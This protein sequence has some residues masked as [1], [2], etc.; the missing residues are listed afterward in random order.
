MALVLRLCTLVVL[1]SCVVVASTATGGEIS[2]FGPK[3]YLRTTGAPNVYQD[4]FAAEPGEAR[5]TIRNGREGQ[6]SNADDRVTSGV[7][8]LNG[9]VLF[10]HDDFKHQTYILE[11]PVILS[12]DNEIRVELESKPGSYLALEIIRTVA[13]PLNDLLAANLAG[14][15]TNC[16]QT[17]DLTVDITNQGEAEIPAGVRVALYN[18][19][20]EDGGQLIG[21]SETTEKLLPTETETVVYRWS[22]P[23]TGD[24]AIFARVD[25]DG[26]GVGHIE[27]IDEL[28]NLVAAEL[29]LCREMP[30]GDSSIA[31]KVIDAVSGAGL[32]D[33]Q[34]VLRPE[35]NGT[36]G[37]AVATARSDA[38]GAFLFA[39]LA[40]GTYQIA[41]VHQ[42][43][44]DNSK[45]VV[46]GEGVDLADQDLVL[47]PVLAD[48]EIRI[49]LTWNQSPADLE[50]HLTQPND[51]GC[52]YHCYYFNK[53]IPTASLDLDDR[54][55][56][57]PE[58]ITITDKIPGTY[59][60]YV[61]DFTNRYANSRWLSLSGAQVKV[62]AGNH[63]PLIFTV[64]G[65]YGN[66]W[67]VFDLNGETGEIVP[68]HALSNQSEPGKIDYPVITSS[69]GGR[70]YW[71]SLYTY[72]VQAT[73]PDNDPLVYALDK[74]PAGMTIDAA[75]G[76]VQWRPS[77]AQSGRYD[78][79]VKVTDDRCGEA[80]QSFTIYVYSQ[81]TAQ[82]SVDPCSGSNPGGDITLK[83]S[84]TL[85]ATVLIEP[86]IGVVEKNGALTIP[87]PAEPTVYT[88]TAFNDAALTKRTVPGLPSASFYFSPNRVYKGQ[89]TTL[90]WTP[91]CANEAVI[92]HDIGTV[93]AAGS[94]NLTPTATTTYNM[95]VGNAAG[96]RNYAATVYVVEP[97]PPSPPSIN[98]S[99]SPTC[100]LTPGEP[101]TLT[102]STSNATSAVISPDIGEVPLAGSQQVTP[103]TAGSYTLEAT[104]D[105]GIRSRTVAYPNYPGVSFSASTYSIDP[106]DS[107]DL[108]WSAGCADTVVINQGIGTVAAQGNLT[109]T[110]PSLPLTYTIT[111]ANERGPVSRSV[112][113]AP[114]GPAG[115]LAADPAVL[116]VG[117]S[118][119]LTWSSTRATS[120]AITPDVGEVDCNGSITITPTRPT[121]YSLK[122]VGPG[123]TAYR[124]VAVSFV[125]PVADLKASA[126]TIK[127]G[128]SV[129]LTW[130]YANATSC[131][132]DQNIG[133]VELGGEITVTP[134]VTTTYT[135][136]STGPGGVARDSVTITVIPANPPPTMTLT[137]GENIILRGSATTLSWDS[138]YADAV[139]I[140]PGIG[141]VAVSGS[142]TVA[143]ETTTIYTAT[144]TGPGGAATAARTITVLQPAPILSLHAVPAAIAGGDSAQL[145]WASTN[146]DQVV[147]NQGIGAVGAEGS[148]AVSPGQ[149]TTYIA[150][151]TGPGGTVAKNVTVTVSQPQPTATLSAAPLAV[152]A[153][154]PTELSWTTAN[155]DTV[156]ISPD[157]G[158]VATT[159]A[160]AVTPTATTTYTL[161]ATG[162]G[163]TVEESV[164]ITVYPELVLQVDSPVAGAVTAT[165]TVAV[166]G[167][168]TTGAAVT[169]NG[170]PATVLGAGFSAEVVLATEG[171]HNL[172]VEAVD[173]YGRRQAVTVTI[174]YMA[175][176]T[177]AIA[178]DR[179]RIAAGDTVTLTWS[180]ENCLSAAITPDPGEVECTGTAQVS[181]AVTTEYIIS[182]RGDADK[183][184]R[185]GVIVVVADPYGDPSA[186]EQAHLE[187]INRARAN[188]AAEAARLG[189]D[190]NEG[191]PEAVIDAAPLPPLTFNATLARA[192]RGHSED[193]VI[194]HYF[195]HEGSD[196]SSPADRCLAAGYVGSTGEN[197]AAVTASDPMDPVRTALQLH[198]NLFVDADYSGRGHRLNILGAEWS[199]IGIG[200]L[201]D[202]VQADAPY[203]GV[204]TCNFGAN[205][206]GGH[207]LL[208]VVYAD[209][210]GDQVYDGGEGVGQ[211][212]VRDRTS[213]AMTY[214]AAA[215][216]YSLPLAD[217]DHTIEVSLADGRTLSRQI[218]M[219][220]ANLKHDFEVGMF[221]DHPPT[222]QFTS[223]DQAVRPGQTTWLEWT[224]TDA[225]YAAIDNGIGYL[226]VNGA[227]A[228]APAETTTYTLTVTGRGGTVTATATVYVSEFIVQ[229]TIAFSAA[230]LTVAKGEATTL[231]W[232]T[233]DAQGVH[234]DNGVGAVAL[235]GSVTVAPDH[236]TTYTLTAV[237]PG[238]VANARVRVLVTGE[239]PPQPAG[240]FG[241]LYNSSIPTD[242]TVEN[243]D[244]ARFALATGAVN[245]R[246]GTPV[247][248]VAVTV[249]HHP[250]YGT[251]VTD[252]GGRFVLPVEGGATYTL[253]YGGAG[254][255]PL[256]RQLYVPVNDI[257]IAPTVQLLKQ[258]GLTTTVRLDGD[259]ATITT[260]RSS[261]VTDDS[262]SRALT[263]VFQGDNRAFAV[264]ED[265]RVV[266]ELRN[267]TV[268]ATEYPTSASMPAELPKTSAYT[269]CAE[270]E[271]DG[272]DRVRFDRP[273]VTWVDNFLGFEVGAAVPVG[274]YDRD[275]GIWVPSRNGVV[276]TLVDS[277]GDGAVDGVDRD[278]DGQADDIDGDGDLRDEAF[279]LADPQFYRPGAEFWRVEV[280][281]FSP[282]DFNW[283]SLISLLN[284]LGFNPPSL[285]EQL[286]P[287]CPQSATGSSVGDASQIYYENIAI[288]GTGLSLAYASDRADGYRQVI[289]VP[290]SGAEVPASVKRIEVE[291]HIAGRK[292]TRTLEPSP[293]QVTEFVWDGRDLLNNR[294]LHKVT[295]EV[296][297][298]YVYDSYY[299]D[300]GYLA[301]AFGWFGTTPTAVPTRDEVINWRRSQLVINPAEKG[302]GLA[303]GWS[304]SAHHRLSPTDPT[305][306]HKGD[307]T[308]IRNATPVIAT[309][310]GNGEEGW[311][312]AGAV[313]RETPISNPVSTVI[314]PAGNIY[315]ANQVHPAILK[316]APTGTIEIVAGGPDGTADEDGI[317]AREA[318]LHIPNDLALDGR[319]N[320]YVADMGSNR[321]RRIDADGIITTIAGNGRQESSG[322][323]GPALAAGIMPS[324]IAVDDAGSI[325]FAEA[326]SCVGGEVDPITG[327]CS[328]GEIVESSYRVRRI[329]TDGIVRTVAGTGDQ[330]DPQVHGS[331]GDGGPADQAYLSGPTSVS[332][333][334]DGN[335][336]IAD[337]ARIR[338]VNPSGNI[339]TVAGNGT[340][341]YSGDG[342]PATL[343][344]I[345]QAAGMAFDH[346]GNFYFSQYYGNGD[347]IRRVGSD[348]YIST[349]AGKGE[350][351]L[352]G[353]DGAATRALLMQPQRLSLDARGRIVIPDRGNRRI[354]RVAVKSYSQEEVHFTEGNGLGYL[355][356]AEGRHR[357][358][359]DLETGVALLEFGYDD[360]GRL[361][362][363]TDQFGKSVTIERTL[364]VATAI[365]SAD[366]LRTG[367]VID[368]QNQLEALT[369]PDG[370]SY[371]FEYL[372]S[373]GLLTAKVE[374]NG[375][376]FE[377][378]FDDTGRVSRTTNQEGGIWQFAREAIAAGLVT[379][380]TSTPN[381]SASVKR[382]ARSTGAV[383]STVT[384][385]SGEVV[386][387][388]TSA[389]GLDSTTTSSCGAKVESSSDLDYWFDHT[390]VRSTRTTTPAGLSRVTAIDRA[391]VDAD[392]DGRLEAVTT[393]TTV[394][395]TTA[396]ARHDIAQAATTVTSAEGRTVTT[397]YDPDTLQPRSIA[398]PGLLATTYDYR[399]DGRLVAVTSGARRTSYSYDSSGNIATITDPL[400]R[401]TRF[402][403]YDG[404]GRVKKIVRPDS[405]ILQFAYDANG[406]MTLYRTPNPADNGFG[407]NRVNNRAA[408][409]SPLGGAT[410]YAYNE[411][412]QLTRVTLPS[413]R[414]ITNTY[415]SGRLTKTATPE[416]VNVYSYACGAN[417]DTITRG[418]EVIDYSY[419]GSLVTGVSQSGT[420]A[421][422]LGLSYNNDFRLATLT[423]GGATEKMEYDKDGLLTGSGGFVIGR[424][425]GNGLAEKVTDSSFTLSRRFNDYGEVD[426]SA[427]DVAG[428]V[429]SY[430]L[431][432]DDGGRIESRTETVAGASRRFQYGY[433]P[434]GRLQTVTRDGILVEEY[435][436]DGNGN[437]SYQMNA[438]LG[439]AG[440]TFSHSIADHTLTAGPV[441]YQFDEDG[442]L[443]A[444]F[445]DGAT[446]RY[447]YSAA[448]ELLRVVRPD[449]AVIAYVHDP[450]GRRIAKQV[451][452]ATVEKYL[453]SGRTTLLAVY[454]GNDTLR[455]RFHYA[456]DR[457]P[458]AMTTGGATYYLAYDQ[459][460]SL[461]LVVDSGGA[462]VKRIDYDS[463]GNILSDSNPGFTIPF[464]FAGGL[465]DRDTGLV[466]FGFRDYLPEIGKW[467]AKDPID[468]A[469]GDSNLYGYVANDPVN[470]I[471][472]DGLETLVII[473]GPTPRNPFGH[474]AIATTGSG[475]YSP[476]NNPNAKNLNYAGSSVTEYIEKES[477]RRESLAF[478][479]PTTS[480]QEEK[481][482]N[483]MK[484]KTTKTEAFPDNCAARVG[485]ALGA[486]GVDLSDPLIPGISLP[487]TAFPAS[488]IRSLK[489]LELQG[490]AHS[491]AIPFRSHN[492]EIFRSFNP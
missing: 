305:T 448:G 52:R 89:S 252:A 35:D 474:T 360:D 13:D 373:D 135:M 141:A 291:L 432:R 63:E 108:R 479:L 45:T 476:G 74:A 270:L 470:F 442:N 243:Y 300:S 258:D 441:S 36:A 94:Q 62:Y 143:P 295:A 154:Q 312:S 217:G 5:L 453:W 450:L 353:D 7:V 79:A 219:A 328:G 187:A 151:A 250:E 257:A 421:A 456:D 371:T 407:Y 202:S 24:V 8:R 451:N 280:D 220:G 452:G 10:T 80:V 419:D 82:F 85:A 269:Y 231:S 469:G 418:T 263:M 393:T 339:T 368:E 190:L 294:V 464:G 23:P 460:G 165:P 109:V 96:S 355:I 435:R 86:G 277:D 321:I 193:M 199:E 261:L 90:R 348:G 340:S 197:I 158:T 4:T 169:V 394:N 253:D 131:V 329:A 146:A 352:A 311:A 350:P 88:L 43:Y 402:A 161:S 84:T 68:V 259:P 116:K 211:V 17:I 2:A 396:T 75:T 207:V 341:G 262:G 278:G 15:V 37:A 492:S 233:T 485:G 20:P 297:I 51:V 203:G 99:I 196:G 351:G 175:I 401:V 337:G 326:T 462:I 388:A 71:D 285:Q 268:R 301:M 283:C 445:E 433:D 333:D 282:W 246:A 424:N 14:D 436:Y 273:V 183:I 186:E 192:A 254:F 44:I 111:A 284:M 385:T 386:T 276:V 369:T 157:I 205:G 114:I 380:T 429:Y 323:G 171:E 115:T 25:D 465:Y 244:P 163:G 164:E 216:G 303:Q 296:D 391:Y 136:T 473:N 471:D 241:A 26:S 331:N 1:V 107:V 191:P 12:G 128:E 160:M 316:I 76:L 423:Y 309:V 382:L 366:G 167:R 77:G 335:L 266:R 198:D 194:N 349:V 184:A 486:G 260:H 21:W 375:N 6:K 67:H 281:H 213:G 152:P 434:L 307:G 264:D 91:S 293:N 117:D 222:L 225:R 290:V 137:A 179:R 78:V 357:L 467:T 166:S 178:A 480:A 272:A 447:T 306:L 212:L 327:V 38:S 338:K 19:D 180:G 378:L 302:H 103:T 218:T 374:P 417:V 121:T 361:S 173:R 53:T 358:T 490:G 27:E 455:Q 101:L 201:H 22:D 181:P 377:H 140:A 381:T 110:P 342:G 347:V 314:D 275:R 475:L 204:I 384:A 416:W 159:G 372:N 112:T 156:T 3:K 113:I 265:G 221:V 138:S 271:I 227:V 431:T 477:K 344:R 482:I 229:P 47:S 325:Y 362:T 66:V 425:S 215:G 292:L 69:P 61:H 491:I 195:A 145:N 365:V 16:P 9:V 414:T 318:R 230:P 274:Y 304:I 487:I 287:D 410:G 50:A 48:N 430:D 30:S 334:R 65:G 428:A 364:G 42:G 286:C 438:D 427:I 466:R 150:T 251:A 310:A 123:G 28:N 170:E 248:G 308:V 458:L 317:A 124:K 200:Y 226:P 387:T 319:G 210:D 57:G 247:A 208:G 390:A 404:V 379:S 439:I 120:C 399:S 395:G 97:P 223:R 463:F 182:A 437:R 139:T 224:T 93:T 267:F 483:F 370:S 49:V 409:T 238:G 454:D 153:G 87:S 56:F 162:P 359:Y 403:E 130:V 449:G 444:R 46:L 249:L 299:M 468:F 324:S 322:D 398:V 41:A 415:S 279:G 288:P 122:M 127:E 356:S 142:T 236:S 411:E 60:Y 64:P 72:Q 289:S 422:A 255:L 367:L 406:N 400:D 132:I 232:T 95:Q 40:A 70:A 59:R 73:D 168:V 443:A 149:T 346:Q 345:T 148:L 245:N 31:G 185:A 118:T 155:A 298:G 34:L 313:A 214:S 144:A 488:I 147:F 354:R 98:F 405:T 206:D 228:V 235:N 336:Y 33:V 242:A 459:V 189:I 237:S 126:T 81:P 18:G 376:R 32:G 489:S 234:I 315:V 172:D 176:P 134:A 92:D 446:T 83:W 174:F 29:S 363:I 119:T 104:G 343:A 383:D 209:A 11:T 413:T 240:S 54:N 133:A 188:P 125:A 100:N 332:V 106:G 389:D 105:G 239:P 461:R 320:L 102:W 440:R 330:Y 457:M 420:L 408:F 426:G 55:G 129:R 484:G 177:V 392:A 39:G 256:Q 412:R 58:T 478:I 472:F 481:I 397:T